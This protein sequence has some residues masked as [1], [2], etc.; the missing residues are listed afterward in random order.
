MTESSKNYGPFRDRIRT[1][2]QLREALAELPEDMPI[3]IDI[4]T[5]SA[6][7]PFDEYEMDWTSLKV[8]ESWNPLLPT[9]QNRLATIAILAHF[10]KGHLFTKKRGR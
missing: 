4:K 9:K 6:K 1:V 3:L 7:Y 5:T 10:A 8:P 2:H